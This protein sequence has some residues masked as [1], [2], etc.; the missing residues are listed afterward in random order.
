MNFHQSKLDYRGNLISQIIYFWIEKLFLK[1]FKTTLTEDD[2]FPCPREQCSKYLFHKFEK[3]WE[4]ELAKK[5]GSDIKIALAKT[6]KSQFIISGVLLLI[7]AILWLVQ[8]VLV[9]Y[10]ASIFTEN[11]KVN[12]ISKINTNNMGPS[13]GYA[14]LISLILIYMVLNRAICDNYAFSAGIQLRTICTTAVYRKA[15]R[16]QQATLHRISIGHV[17]NLVSNDVYKLEY[18]LVYW[19]FIWI[20]PIVTILSVIIALIY[21]GPI[22]LLGFAYIALHIPMQMIT[23]YIFGRFRYLQSITADERVNLMGQIIRG[24]RVIKLYVWE[25]SFLKYVSRIRRKEVRYAS[26]AGFTQSTTLYFYNN[27]LFISLFIIYSFGV[28]ANSPLTSAELA[29]AY[30]IFNIVRTYTV[31]YYGNGILTG[32][33]SVVALKRIQNILELSESIKSCHTQS[34]CS[35]IENPSI[36][37]IDF[38]ASWS[39]TGDSNCSNNLVLKR[40]NLKVDRARLVA[41]AGPLGSG[42][43]SLLTSLINELPGVSGKINIIGT[44]S[45]AAQEP[46]IF[47]GTIQNNILFGNHLNSYRYRQVVAACSLEEDFGSFPEG[48]LTLIGERGVTLSGGQKARVALARAVYQEADIYLLDDPL[49][50]V[51]VKVGRDIFE[52]CVRGFLIDKIVLL[53]THHVQYVKQAEE[54]AVMREGSVVCNGPYGCV[55]KNE[56]CRKFLCELE[57]I[58][59]RNVSLVPI[60][61]RSN[62]MVDNLEEDEDGGSVCGNEPL[63]RFSTKE[64]YRPNSSS[65]MTYIHYFW[66]GG[67][68]MTI[69]LLILTILS[70]A[71]LFLS[72]WWMQSITTCSDTLYQNESVVNFDCPWYFS[73]SSYESIGLL[74]FI[75]FTG[76]V[77]MCFSAFTFY[78]ILLQ[79]SRRLHNRMLH[80][81]LYCPMSFFQSNPSGRILNRFSKDSGF[82]DEQLPFF[83]YVFWIY[84]SYI[85][86]VTIASCVTQYII[87]VP[88]IISLLLTLSLRYYYLKT[89]TQVKRLESVARS[90]LYS[91]ISIS[92]LGLSTIH[93]LKNEERMTQDFHYFQD[94]H[95][96]AWYHYA[97]C[98]RWFESRL[99]LMASLVSISGVFLALFSHY[100]LEWHQLVGFSLPLLLSIPASFHYLVRRS[101]DVELLMVSVDRIKNY[102][103]LIQEDTSSVTFQ[104]PSLNSCVRVGEIEFVNVSFKYSEEFP[105]S[106][107]NFSLRIPAGEKVGIIGRTGA[108]KSSLFNALC[109]MNEVSEGCIFIDG[110]DISKLHLYAHRKRLSVIP[111]DPVLFSGTLR[112]NLDPFDEFSCEEIWTAVNSCHLQEMVGRL[113]DQLMSRV[114]EDGR[115]FSTGERQLLC[116]ARAILRKNRIILID[117][118]TANVDLHTDL[119]I[120]QAIRTNFSE[121]TV[122]TIAHRI[123]TI[124]DSHRI[125]VL[126]KGGLIEF[127]MPLFM[128]E[129]ENSYLRN[130]MTHLDP[131]SQ[132]KMRSLAQRSYSTSTFV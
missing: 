30:L 35:S 48:D 92:L 27:S 14:I 44:T 42:K 22:S 65:I 71:L 105:Y 115:N 75:T 69:L 58:E 107:T 120:Q 53:V 43:S 99:H 104:L 66:T 108:G 18:G 94:K 54:I 85:I 15:I 49:S 33:E 90:P 79:A 131:F 19:N 83:F 67:L 114:E 80:K 93:A 26:L 123:E 86:A 117:E 56:F 8:A 129:K 17:L 112:Y 25:K 98:S 32:R 64:D 60:Y 78:Y 28:V 124:I 97:M 95:S 126:N 45:Y 57:M 84:G 52:N 121:C 11:G 70:N 10:F 128:L 101:C 36:E 76:S 37:L 106:L 51:D 38:T 34:T 74:A 23:G 109:R 88:F 118:A 73:D 20:S 72:Y 127:D 122:L 29:L 111:Q 130:L 77:C 41:I 7:D 61:D 68:F 62:E 82:L 63:S 119:L 31:L 96:T 116:L 13:L 46:W 81:V 9:S 2:L 110:V 50:A 40:I 55:V 16:L 4:I 47:S 6:L 87:V 89:S 102:C 91:H 125:V 5:G 3:Y 59:E 132:M 39:R 103:N 1:G 24:I 21:I 12:N 113:P 100:I